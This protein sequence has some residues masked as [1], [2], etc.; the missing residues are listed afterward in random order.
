MYFTKTAACLS[1]CFSIGSIHPSHFKCN[2]TKFLFCNVVTI[3][4]KYPESKESVTISAS[5]HIYSAQTQAIVIQ[6][7]DQYIALQAFNALRDCLGYATTEK[8][9]VI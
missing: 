2:V 9:Q 6:H 8:C 3:L 7:P 4:M 5:G 1:S